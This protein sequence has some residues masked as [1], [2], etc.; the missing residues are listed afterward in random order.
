MFK[1]IRA[2]VLIPSLALLLLVPANAAAA[3]P[4]TV[5]AG[6]SSL[7]ARVALTVPVTV[8][9]PPFDPILT[10]QGLSLVQEYIAVNVEQASGRQIARGSSSLYSF[11]PGPWSFACDGGSTTINVMVL[12][13]PAGP[14]FHGGQASISTGAS[15]TMGFATPFGGYYCPCASQSASAI[16]IV[17]VSH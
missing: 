4:M 13:D 15:A 3:N 16:N 9:C 5:S 2:L 6:N 1:L 17:Q 10:T 8:S 7:A 11:T 14:P 12:A